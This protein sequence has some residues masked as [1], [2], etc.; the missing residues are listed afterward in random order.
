MM[1]RVSHDVR[2]I[3]SHR[4][5]VGRFRSSLSGVVVVVSHRV[6]WL[7]ASAQLLL[8]GATMSY[9]MARTLSTEVRDKILQSASEVIV[10]VGIT[11]FTVEEVVRRS[12]VART[13]H[14][15]SLRHRVAAVD[16]RSRPGPSNRFPRRTPARS[17]ATCGPTPR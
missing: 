10:D 7:V 11:G 17:T 16:R 5:L 14:L 4:C 15:S 12:G 8:L 2:G 13:T 3:R 6:C 1:W 9:C